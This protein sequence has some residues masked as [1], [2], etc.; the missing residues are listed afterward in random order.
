MYDSQVFAVVNPEDGEA[1]YCSIMGNAEFFYGL[2]VYT[3][4]EGLLSYMKMVASAHPDFDD[5]ELPY[6]Q[7]CLMASFNDRAYLEA[8]DL[9]LIKRLGL[10]FRG[11]NAWPRFRCHRP[12]LYPWPLTSPHARFLT[13][14]LEQAC[15]VGERAKTDTKLVLPNNWDDLLFRVP[16]KTSSCLSWRD[17]RRATDRT[18]PYQRIVPKVDNPDEFRSQFKKTTPDHSI[19]EL[20]CFH[21]PAVLKDQEPY[22]FPLMLLAMVPSQGLILGV[23]M[24]PP[25]SEGEQGLELIE[26]FSKFGI[27]TKIKFQR[28]RALDLFKEIL[29][30]VGITAE[31]SKQSKKMRQVKIQLMSR[32]G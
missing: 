14:A 7:S 19:W 21:I 25:H 3:G 26:L 17:E 11:R 12:G 24:F 31:L 6:I 8:G 5:D 4:Q 30:L 1:G 2:G 15:Q 32:F 27:P 16:T 22:Y 20:D 18:F 28:E 9:Q 10:T 13:H 23:K 29:D